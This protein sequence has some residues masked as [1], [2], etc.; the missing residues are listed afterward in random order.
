MFE[1]EARVKIS[2]YSSVVI[3]DSNI[4]YTIHLLR[5]TLDLR[6][7]LLELRV[8]SDHDIIKGLYTRFQR[9]EPCLLLLVP[10]FDR[11]IRGIE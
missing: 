4:T 10:V 9:C 1:R 5:K 6:K 3:R 2:Y 7:F 8:F 11:S